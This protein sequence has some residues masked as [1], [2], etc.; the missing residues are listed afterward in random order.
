MLIE[1]IPHEDIKIIEHTYRQEKKKPK[2]KSTKPSERETVFT[3][4]SI[5]SDDESEYSFYNFKT[6]PSKSK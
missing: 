6:N 5:V 1:N 4:K 2:I 3:K